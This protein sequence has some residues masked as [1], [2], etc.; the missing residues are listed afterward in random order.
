MYEVSKCNQGAEE[1]GVRVTNH[2]LII[3]HHA[4]ASPHGGSGPGQVSEDKKRLP[5]HLCA[6][7]CYNVNNLAMCGEQGVELS[8]K[9]V[10][11][12]LIVK[13]FN[14]ERHVGRRHGLPSRV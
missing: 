8:T 4:F 1:Y 3:K 2:R 6:F 12:N 11:L 9:L 10:L 7:G 5:T 13:I 14:V